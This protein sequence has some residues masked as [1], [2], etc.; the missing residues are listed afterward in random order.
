MGLWDGIK[1]QLRSVIEWNNPS[2]GDLI[3]RWD[4]S[5]DEL[6]NASKLIV[7]PGQAAIFVYEG[8]VKAVHT[9]PGLFDLTTANIPFWTT[10]SKFMQAFQSEH[11]ADVYFVRMTEFL[12]QKWGTKSP[13]K[14]E[15]PKYKFPVGLRAFGNFSFKITDPAAFFV[16]VS[17]TRKAFTVEEIRSAIVDRIR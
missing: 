1:G 6:K 2:A 15:D 13:V 10:I 7:G 9:A 8:A 11:K 3:W 12:D 17:S 4:G 5:G 14:Y 16:N